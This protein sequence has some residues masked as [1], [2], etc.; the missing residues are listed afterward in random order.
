MIHKPS[1]NMRRLGNQFDRLR[2]CYVEQAH[3]VPA[4]RRTPTSERCRI[5]PCQ[6]QMTTR[7]RLPCVPVSQSR[8][9]GTELS[10]SGIHF[11]DAP[12]T[13]STPGATKGTLTFMIGGDKTVYE[14]VKPFFEAMG[15]NLYYCGGPGLGL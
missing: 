6:S 2:V 4:W 15:K 9:I 13:G 12:C 7:R 11:L 3:V 14:R 1:P 10:K 8:A 5:L